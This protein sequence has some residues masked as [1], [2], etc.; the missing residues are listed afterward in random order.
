MPTDDQK[1]A[2]QQVPVPQPALRLHQVT[3]TFGVTCA[4]NGADLSLYPGRIHALLGE[5][6]AGKSTMV[7][8]VVGAIRADFGSIEIAGK[9]GAASSVGDAIA[10][11]IVPI[12][13]HLSLFPHMSVH[14]NLSAFALGSTSNVL[15]SRVLV[16]A[17][18]A[19][20]WLAAVELDLPLDMQVATLSVGQR[21]LIEIARGVGRQCRILVLDEP[22][23]ALTEEET[24]KLFAVVRRLASEGAAILFISHKLDEVEALADDVSVLRDG[25][26]VI[27][28]QP[29]KALSR[30]E[31]V[32]AMIG[33]DVGASSKVLP[34][35][36]QTILRARGLKLPGARRQFDLDLR[37]GEIVGFV[38]LVGSGALSLGAALAGAH[39]VASGT[40]AV[41]D[42][43]IPAG[44]RSKAVAAGIGYVPSD[45][46]TEGLFP[47][48]SAISNTT[49]STLRRHMRAGI[50]S[51][52]AEQRSAVP[53][54]SRLGLNPFRPD[55]DAASFSGGNQQK[56]LI[57]RNLS[58]DPLRTLV[59]LEPTRG[60][61]VGAREVI[62]D[63]ILEAA[64]RGVGIVI[65]SSDIKEVL[66][67]SHRVF[68]V[69]QGELID[70]VGGGV[71]HGYLMGLLAGREAA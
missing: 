63:V 51:K 18:K 4:L 38:G 47:L 40:I 62:H 69:R 29:V 35:I 60:V 70:E 15:R 46:Q 31:I 26:T 65:A 28:C 56:L 68:V 32:R 64:R 71:D 44:D 52:R 49:V 2:G 19:R 21:Q 22:T 39:S 41:N 61:D 10:R 42:D 57:C 17:D 34:E 12:Y 3:K 43:I 37:A 67:L 59:V 45:R 1:F 50:L 55:D 6:G 7:K 9:S 53:L 33:A 54:L 25:R 8:L 66:A 58:L 48:L 24:E 30:K 16:D 13:Q 11:C 14:E 27:D 36:G 23:A 20:S 5:N